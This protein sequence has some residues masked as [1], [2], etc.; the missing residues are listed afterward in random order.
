MKTIIKICHT[1]NVIEFIQVAM[2]YSSKT[3]L[4][5]RE[6]ENPRYPILSFQK[7]DRAST[8]LQERFM[9]KYSG[10]LFNNHEIEE[11]MKDL[12]T[13]RG[14]YKSIPEFKDDELVIENGYL[15]LINQKTE[16]PAHDLKTV[17]ID[18]LSNGC[19]KFKIKRN[20][21]RLKPIEFITKPNITES[22]LR[23]LKNAKKANENNSKSRVIEL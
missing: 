19:S 3:V 23:S 10:K 2:N 1:N 22:V 14:A 7:P 20:D 8:I 17:E 18:E 12:G 21:G 4:D 9:W 11:V 15:K 5:Y 6:T 16:I 13:L